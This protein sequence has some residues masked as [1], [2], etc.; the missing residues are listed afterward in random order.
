[1]NQLDYVELGNQLETT[2]P[3]SDDKLIIA[4]MFDFANKFD[5]SS[6]TVIRRDL[7]AR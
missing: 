7:I 4:F 2:I 5:I 1:M 6:F 3:S